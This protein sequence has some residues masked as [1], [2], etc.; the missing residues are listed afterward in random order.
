MMSQM[1]AP[2]NENRW[3]KP[4]FTDLNMQ[5]DLLKEAIGRCMFRLA[6][7]RFSFVTVRFA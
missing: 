7:A 3:L 6:I 4:M 1:T 2:E 5:A